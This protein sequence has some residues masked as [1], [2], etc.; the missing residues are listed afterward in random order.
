MRKILFVHPGFKLINNSFFFF[1]CPLF[2]RQTRY[3]NEAE[4][5]YDNALLDAQHWSE[6][7]KAYLD[8]GLHTEDV[9]LQTPSPPP[10]GYRPGT[11]KPDKVRVALSEPRLQY[12]NQVG[13][14]SEWNREGY[15]DEVLKFFKVPT[16]LQVRML[17]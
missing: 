2:F 8:F 15:F 5:L 7:H 10:G 17:Y 11:P 14:I 3:S 13:Y 9:R 4:F 12:V 1:N 16:V 6:Q